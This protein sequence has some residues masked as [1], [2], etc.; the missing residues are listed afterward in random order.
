MA[1]VAPAWDEVDF[2]FTSSGYVPP[3]GGF[4]LM[5]MA[6]DVEPPVDFF[7]QQV[8]SMADPPLLAP[9]FYFQ[10]A[11]QVLI[12]FDDPPPIYP[13]VV[14]YQTVSA[15]SYLTEVTAD[16][17]GAEQ[18]NINW[19]IPLYD[20]DLTQDIQRWEDLNK[21]IAL[22][23][24]VKGQELT[25]L[26][27]DPFDFRSAPIGTV[28]TKDDQFIGIGDGST[29]VFQLQKTYKIGNLS[30]TLDIKY[31]DLATVLASVNG[32][33]AAGNIPDPNTGR[34]FMDVVPSLGDI[35]T[36]G[37]E[38]YHRVR[39]DSDELSIALENYKRGNT[40]L[41]VTEVRT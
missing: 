31:P 20:F 12:E 14:S 25:F 8:Y 29:A 27:K 34:L 18:R 7:W 17:S 23:K 35:V 19:P 30:Q 38:Y 37:F 1:Y 11:Y 4:I 16:R 22:F 36:A 40:S 6:G 10:E 26:V 21:I 33:P 32:G 15:I 39:F 13:L 3:G 41:R 28:V 2:D 5:D 9:D 24:T